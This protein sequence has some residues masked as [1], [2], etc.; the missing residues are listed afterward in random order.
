MSLEAWGDEGDYDSWVDRALDAGWL[1]PVD[2]S[3]AL[4][5]V[6]KERSRQWDEEGFGPAHDDQHAGGELALA[7]CAYAF[8]VTMKPEARERVSGI[9]TFRNDETLRD[10]WPWSGAW[11]K[12][13]DPRR[14]LVKAAALIVAEIERY[15]RAA[16]GQIT[17][18]APGIPL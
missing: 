5:D 1:D 12:P 3:Q 16:K 9:G 7:A 18:G 2:L 17:N 4:R 6:M 13:T 8:A 10:L 11:W 14:D 15:D